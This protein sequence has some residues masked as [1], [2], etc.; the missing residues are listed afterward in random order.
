MVA[1][2]AAVLLIATATLIGAEWPQFR[3]PMRDNISTETGLFRTWPAAGPKVLWKTTV[4]DGYAGAAIK[5][6]VVYIN[7]YEMVK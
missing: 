6:G 5:D 4:A 3:G 2:V 7:D 1:R